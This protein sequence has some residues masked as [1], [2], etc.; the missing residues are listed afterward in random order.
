MVE[1]ILSIKGVSVGILL[2]EPPDRDEIRIS[3]RAK[4]EYSIRDLA[5]QFNGGGHAQAAGAR[6]PNGKID[7]VKKEIISK[8]V[9]LF[10][11]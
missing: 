1:S 9:S 8:S 4:G 2:I 10:L 7:E 5:L 11:R 3:F 6:V